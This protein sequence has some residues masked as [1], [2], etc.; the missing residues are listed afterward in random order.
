MRNFAVSATILAAGLWLGRMPLAAIPDYTE[1]EKKECAFC[2]PGGDLFALND[3]GQYYA[4]HHTLEGYGE[5]A[6]APAKPAPTKP[7]PAKPKPAA[8]EPPKPAPA[9]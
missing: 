1:K 9:K 4:M 8:G 3:A 6:P 7:E 5:P 2:H